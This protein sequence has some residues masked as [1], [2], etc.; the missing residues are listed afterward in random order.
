MSYEMNGHARDPFGG[1][2]EQITTPPNGLDVIDPRDQ[3][4]EAP[5]Y[6]PR[7]LPAV[8]EAYVQD[9]IASWGGDPGPYAASFMAM[10]AGVLHSSVK[11]ATNPLKPDHW[12][13]PND[14]SLI[15]GKSGEVK[16]GMYKDLTRHQTQ[17]QQAM[18]RAQSRVQS[19]K[20]AHP[21]MCFLQNAS[22]EGMMAQIA[23]NHGERLLM[24]SEE[25]MGF[26]DGAALHHRDNAVNAMSNAVCAAYDGSMFNKRLVTKLYMIPEALAT[27]VMTTTIDK[28]TNWKGFLAMVDSGLMAR[29]TISVIAHRQERDPTK[30][31]PDAD[32]AMGAMLLKLRGLRD[33][34]FVLDDEAADKWLGYIGKREAINLQLVKECY[35]VGYVNWWRKYD[36]RI[37][38]CAT[39]LQAYEFI[40]GGMTAC[41]EVILPRTEEDAGKDNARVRRTVRITYPNLQRAV[42]FTEGFLAKLQEFFYRIA[43]GVTEFGDELMNFIAYRVTMDDPQVPEGRIIVRGDLTYKGPRRLRGAVTAERKEQHKR[44]IQALLDHGFI[45]VYEHPN[46]RVLKQHRQP[47]EERWFKVRDELFQYFASEADRTWLREH[48][49]KSRESKTPRD[50]PGLTLDI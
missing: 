30:L 48:Y 46:A 28:V 3:F 36:M 6:K 32:K 18:V 10:H 43:A 11:M 2:R 35:P 23:D 29:H 34:R 25:A 16:S 37:M 44:W 9:C 14:F 42:R 50:D 20:K 45:E 38:T 41:E 33:M 49:E 19:A 24:A 39:L 8:F 17:W 21:P 26:Y 1:E 31:V 22:I 7:Y 27:L 40:E 13:N 47:N 15:L 4:R 5:E 12:R